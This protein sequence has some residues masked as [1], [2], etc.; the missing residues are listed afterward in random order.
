MGR[1]LNKKYFGN[2]NVGSA[3][4]TADDGIGGEGLGAWTLPAQKGVVAITNTYRYFPTLTIPAPDLVEGV[5][6]TATVVWELNTVTFSS[7]GSGYT[8]NQ[9]GV[10]ID[11]L[12]GSIY[13]SAVTQPVITIDTNGSGAVSAVY[14]DTNNRG[15]W[16]SIDGTSITTWAIKQG[17]NSTAQVTATFRLK[18]ITTVEKGSGYDTAP[19]F[20]TSSWARASSQS[21]GGQTQTGAP[22]VALTVDSGNF[23]SDPLNPG[24]NA[25]DN[26]ENAIKIYANIGGSGG[27]LSD[28]VKQEGQH[29]YKVQNTDGAD[30]VN[31]VV[32]RANAGALQHGEAIIYA[33][34]SDNNNYFVSKLTAHKATLYQGTGTQFA[35]ATAVSWNFSTAVVNTDPFPAV[36]IDNG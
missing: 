6:A 18:S 21:A 26:Q 31:L 20:T 16:T 34:D 32:N 27:V 5:Q 28:I 29:R 17:A 22:S 13:T 35:N 23:S 24:V 30:Y 3:S 11:N 9:S 12:V 19:S 33:T 15:T 10:A 8:I 14:L 7:G 25:T 36:V 1:P 4:T 2:R